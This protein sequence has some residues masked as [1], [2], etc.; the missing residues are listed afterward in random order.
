[1]Y[2]WMHMWTYLPGRGPRMHTLYLSHSVYSN[3]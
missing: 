2:E 3:R 1:M